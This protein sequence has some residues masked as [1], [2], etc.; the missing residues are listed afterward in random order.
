[1]KIIYSQQPIPNTINKSIFLAGPSLR[2]G[3]EG[4]SWRLKALEILKL[5]QYD[6]IVFV[7]EFEGGV[8]DENFNWTNQVNWESRCLRCADHIL[9]HINRN[10]DSGLLGL[11]TNTEFGQWMN[12]GKCVL[13]LPLN[14]DKTEY[15]KYWAENLK[16][17]VYQDLF[18]AI[19][20][21]LD[22]QIDCYRKDGERFIPQEIFLLDRFRD[23]YK[24]MISSGNWISDAKVLNTY[25]IPSNNKIFAYSLWVN[26]YI[27]SENRYK[28]NEFIFSRPDISNCVL[29]R[30]DKENILNSDI[31]L[32]SE[33]RSPV[34]NEKVMVYELPGGSSVKPDVD[35]KERII[36]ELSEETGFEPK[37]DKLVFEDERQIYATL[38]TCK[39]YLYSY[40]LDDFEF[41]K[42]KENVD[43]KQT[44]GN[45]ED[46]E[47]TYL[48]IFKVSEI[49]NTKYID[50]S[51]VGQ[52]LK[53]INKKIIYNN[54]ILI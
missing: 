3:Q 18:N 19:T 9:F 35:P 10:I 8:F 51:N 42:I 53:V 11:T 5:L 2:P 12:S 40:E 15:Q 45:I 49:L 1:M 43:T 4:V 31:V 25:R 27:K 32:V 34:N 17:P 38:V 47:L 39:S 14:A 37:I 26:I 21:I 6:G 7:P 46:T 24:N 50:W 36:E 13:S 44:F 22:N 23:W 52:I 16:V 28:N 48:H 41:L 20:H 29:Y 30:L 54:K 33:F